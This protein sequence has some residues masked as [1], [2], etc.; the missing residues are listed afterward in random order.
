[1]SR[2][3]IPVALP[4]LSQ[5][6]IN[7]VSQ[8]IRSGW[9]TQGPRV[10]EFEQAIAAYTGA[11]YACATS[12]GTSAL[13]L[14]LLVAG[15]KP[16]DWVLTVS[17]TYI[18][19]ANAIR[20]C[21]AEP[22][23]I[24]IEKENYNISIRELEVLAEKISFK[25]RTARLKKK[26]VGAL[27][28]VHQLGMPAPMTHINSLAKQL[29]IPVIE[30]AA[31]ALGSEILVKNKWQHIGRPH[32]LL[33]CFSFHPRKI[34]TTGDGGIITTNNYRLYQRLLRLRQ[35]GMSILDHARHTAK[36]VL[37]ES[38]DELGY[39]Y[40]LTDLQAAMG[41]AQLT[42]LPAMIKQRR[43]LVEYYRKRLGSIE[44]LEL[45]PEAE[46]V[47]SN[48]Q[49]FCV[50]LPRARQKKKVMQA[51]LDQNI[52]TRRAV[53][54]CHKEKPYRNSPATSLKNSEAV[55]NRGLILPLYHQLTRG[56]IDR[57][58]SALAAALRKAD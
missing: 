15:V 12:N 34:I 44:G 8:V 45:P 11:K 47:R 49:S 26:R 54:N 36:K 14:A 41:L 57:I 46:N 53:M 21:G 40:R 22:W 58:A 18:A 4:N 1:M 50:M 52:S 13:H 32:G 35:H 31:C 30:D 24:D 29:N 55:Q 39:N 38:Y 10:K 7:E 51:L 43:K 6:E 17:H 2:K 42:K 9:V 5:A 28:P 3:K 37:I 48:W 56:D 19:V 27:I 20:M 25:N 33:A 23:F 16:G